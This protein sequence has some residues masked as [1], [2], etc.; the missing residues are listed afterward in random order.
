MVWLSALEE[1]QKYVVPESCHVTGSLYINSIQ[2]GV[3]EMKKN[4]IVS[5]FVLILIICFPQ[6]VISA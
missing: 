1:R 3:I 4:E 6:T 5:L 2:Y